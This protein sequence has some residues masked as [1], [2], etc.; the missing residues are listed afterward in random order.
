MASPKSAGTSYEKTIGKATGASGA[1]GSGDEPANTEI[2]LSQEQKLMFSTPSEAEIDSMMNDPELEFAPQVWKLEEGKMVAGFLEGYGP[3]AELTRIDRVTKEETISV[4]NTWILAAP[5]GGARISILS[6]VQL[7]KKLPQFI[8]SM[9]RIHRGKDVNTTSGNRV[10]QYTVCGPK[11]ADGVRRSWAVQNA[12]PTIDVKSIE[13]R[14][15]APQLAAP[16]EGAES[17]LS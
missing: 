3:P 5:N 8:G 9:V 16:V 11:R 13:Q 1:A 14:E 15:P 2:V 7:D 10:T 12:L 17:P 4:V 6:S